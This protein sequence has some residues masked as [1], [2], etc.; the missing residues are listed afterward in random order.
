VILIV[1]GVLLYRNDLTE[2]NSWLTDLGVNA[3]SDL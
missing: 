1:M 3:I 2:L